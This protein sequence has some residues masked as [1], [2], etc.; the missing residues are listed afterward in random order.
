[1]SAKLAGFG[2]ISVILICLTR[3]RLIWLS[4]CSSLVYIEI[5]PGNVK[6]FMHMNFAE[7]NQGYREIC[8][9]IAGRKVGKA[10]DLMRPL[11]MECHNLEISTQLESQA[12]T[13]QNLLIY[14]FVQYEDPEK[15][16]IYT[17]LLRSLFGL[18]DRIRET[19]VSRHHI[20]SYTHLKR[21]FENRS[22]LTERDSS[23]IVDNLAFEQEVRRIL[24]DYSVEGDG[25]VEEGTQLPH[26]ELRKIFQMLWLSDV[27]REPEDRLIKGLVMG[28]VLPW[29]DKCLVVSA[30][31][32]SLLRYFDARKI[33]WL[34]D[35]YEAREEQVWHR[36]MAGLVIALYLYDDRITSYPDLMNRISL[37]QGNKDFAR[38]LEL[39]YIQIIKSKE[40]EK[41]T[42]KFQ[43]ELFPE[44]MRL[45]PRL[46]EKLDLD[47]II[48]E[49]LQ[50]DKNPDWQSIMGGSPGLF[51]KLEEFSMLQMEGSDVFLSAF[52]L[53]KQ[54]DFFNEL[55][56]WFVPF[57]KENPVVKESLEGVHDDFDV[58]S[59]IAGLQKS[60]FICN[61]D[62]YSFCLNVNRMPAIQKSMMMQL[63]NMEL[64]GM[65]EISKDDE[66]LN[67][68][69]IDRA[70]FTQYFQ[71]LYR[72]NKLHPFKHEFADIFSLPFDIYRTNFYR[73]SIDDDTVLK[74][75]G[76]FYFA[77][78]YYE[79]SLNIFLRLDQEESPELWQKMAY[80][81]QNLGQFDKAVNLYERA[82]LLESASV[83]TLKKTAWCYRKLQDYE[84][85]LAYYRKAEMLDP[86]D[87]QIQTSL[88]HTCLDMK[89]Y[90]TALKYYYKVSYLAPGNIRVQRPIAWC[91]FV[92]GRFESALASFTEIIKK[93]GN[94]HDYMNLGHVYWCLGNKAMAIENYLNSLRK[95][96][97]QFDWFEPAFIE[98]GRILNGFGIPDGDLS[99]MLD[100]L[101][102]TLR[103]EWTAK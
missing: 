19:L 31:T 14:S 61:S 84:K 35:I 41:I 76:E 65:N 16:H 48:S 83:W 45:R 100:Y 85:A 96:S 71:D 82:G 68:Y 73:L 27:Y 38:N 43:E 37:Y 28:K 46:D 25:K 89:D 97:Y 98:D 80:A 47:H 4:F 90:E 17:H 9:L 5:Y 24:E 75:V 88:G 33:E 91:S 1:M 59:F 72:F 69:A 18:A 22:V 99:L 74:N 64:N 81:Y 34:F 10:I 60:S 23:E 29:H 86:D 62:K 102:L 3:F 12:E 70:I 30:I 67:R 52:A 58:D 79:E 40:T 39:I 2:K 54:F 92:L 66:M 94:K 57:Y 77:K 93:E 20:L 53:L 32:L 50:E 42:R 6:N 55:C 26:Y 21:Q 51:E 13:Y 101:A 95:A 56:N 7:L 49:A 36:A 15:D 8:R 63:F 11:S 78:G 87:L 103:D 44:M